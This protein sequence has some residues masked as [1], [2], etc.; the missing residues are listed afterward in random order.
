MAPF[1]YISLLTSIVLAIGITRIL[2]GIGKIVQLRG[3]LRIYWVHLLWSMNVF[4]WL[5]LNW[6]I[7]FR[8]HS[9]EGW[10][11]FLFLFVLVSPVVAF[12]LSVVLLPE[13]LEGGTDLKKLFF[14]NQRWFFTLAA[15][16]PPIDAIDTLLKGRDH[17]LAQGVQYPIVLVI[18]FSLSIIGMFSKNE[19]FHAGFAIFFLLFILAFI[20][21][22]LRILT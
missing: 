4:L 18:I 13:P 17:F 21:V 6:W 3:T 8:W 19:R 15:L 5:L 10:T 7:L 1:E 9:Y 14:A 11:F 20:S 2:T 16:L 22:N 12:L